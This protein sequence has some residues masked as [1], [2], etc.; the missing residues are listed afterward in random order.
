MK[1]IENRKS[2]YYKIHIGAACGVMVIVVGNAYGDTS[3]NPGRDW[4]HFP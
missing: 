3:S 4:L 2:T 1:C